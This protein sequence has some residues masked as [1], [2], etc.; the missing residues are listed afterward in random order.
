[1]AEI[2]LRPIEKSDLGMIQRWR[3]QSNVLPYCR[4][5]RPLSI[6][7]M[8]AW[9]DKL[10]IDKDY[11][12]TNDFFIIEYNKSIGVGGFTRID[13][14]NRK[15]ELSFYVSEFDEKIVGKALLHLVGYGFETLNLFKIYWPVYSFNPH[16]KVYEEYFNKEYTAKKEYY[17]EGKYHDRIVLVAYN[18]YYEETQ[19]N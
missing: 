11:N 10:H 15:A 8:E 9:Y 7:D 12:L 2:T 1:M 4:Q 13:W 3:N 18:P 14:R 19:R 5:Y 16:I 17:W 6:R